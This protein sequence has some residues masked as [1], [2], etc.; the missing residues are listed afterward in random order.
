MLIV[1]AVVIVFSGSYKLTEAVL[2]TARENEVKQC[3]E[4]Q[5]ENLAPC[6]HS[7]QGKK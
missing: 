2:G 1:I 5:V 6:E 7:L 3:N 4:V